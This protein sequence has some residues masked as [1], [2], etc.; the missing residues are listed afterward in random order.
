[1]KTSL[2]TKQIEAQRVLF[3][4]Y[5]A[6]INFVINPAVPFQRDNED[7]DNYLFPESRKRWEVWLHCVEVNNI[8]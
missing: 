8:K 3:E 2:T 4:K 7:V 6:T 1:M 5:L